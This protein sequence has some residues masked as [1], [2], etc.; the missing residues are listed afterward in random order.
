M[1]QGCSATTS[2]PRASS[3]QA[4]ADPVLRVEDLELRSLL[5]LLSDRQIYEGSTVDRALEGVT[6]TRRLLALTLARL[7]DPRGRPA[8]ELLLFDDTVE[9]RR[10]AVFALGRL[11]S[12]ESK[13]ALLQMAVDGDRRTGELAVASL[14]AIG[15]PL[16]KVLD[17]LQS[18]PPE[19]VEARLLPDLH[20]FSEGSP[21]ADAQR[22][23]VAALG[24]KAADGWLRGRAVYALTLRPRSESRQLLLGLLDDSEP[25]VRSLAA[26][27]LGEVGLGRDLPALRRVALDSD[28]R[29][30][31]AAL[32]SGSAILARGEA[33][34]PQEWRPLLLELFEDDRPTVRV[35]ALRCSAQWLLDDELGRHLARRAKDASDAER[36]AALTALVEGSDPRA[37][38]LLVNAALDESPLLRAAAARLGDGRLRDT[39]RED[40]EQDPVPMVRQAAFE[41]RMSGSA[42]DLGALQTWIEDS[43]GGVRAALFR[44]LEKNP[45]LG[46]ETLV[47][48]LSGPGREVLQLSLL[49]VDALVARALAKPTERGTIVAVLE[50]LSEARDFLVR[51]QAGAGLGRLGRPVPSPGQADS[52]RALWIYRD[53]V[54]RTAAARRVEVETNRG[55]FVVSLDCPA[56]PLTCLHFVQLAEQGFYRGLHFHRVVPGLLV[57]GGDPRGDG[58]GGPGFR[59]RDEVT[60]RRLTAGSLILSRRQP[61][62]AGSQFSILLQESPSLEGDYTIIGRIID[63]LEIASELVVGDRIV[64]MREIPAFD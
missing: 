38:D 61:H 17:R 9:V 13:A 31:V 2:A 45:I 40:L 29:V 37:P 54:R 25:W 23:A 3:A 33:A 49:A 22:E 30:A 12:E 60:P 32:R 8:L 41:S 43:D 1:I 28:S 11:R 57:E 47:A 58:W 7:E 46:V 27:A 64:D 4:L 10:L 35:A 16:L 56:T 19:E 18:L 53:V 6:A 20:L 34:A 26:G 51:L 42:P 39:L 21:F 62:T 48:A 36:L 14:A 44:W 63:G 5:L 15:V 24:A 59:V 52:L 55:S 50:R